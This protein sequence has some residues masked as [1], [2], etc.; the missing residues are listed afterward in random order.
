MLKAL[1]LVGV[2]S[3]IGGCM[4][5]LIAFFLTRYFPVAFPVGTFTVNMLGCLLIGIVYGWSHRYNWINEDIK[6]FLTTGICGG[7]TTFSA[8]AFE[9]VALFKNGY[10]LTPVAYL[11]MSLLGGLLLVVAGIKIAQ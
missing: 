2:G 3:M 4:R 11:V 5:Y 6:I 1:L 7:F 10:T 8:L 9:G